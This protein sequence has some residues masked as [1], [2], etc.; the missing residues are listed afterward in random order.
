MH[1]AIKEQ[2]LFDKKPFLEHLRHLFERSSLV[3]EKAREDRNYKLPFIF[4]IALENTKAH[5]CIDLYNALTVPCCKEVNNKQPV[6]A[7][8]PKEKLTVY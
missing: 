8:N 7:E 5:G 4:S 6:R 3:S 1:C 2:N